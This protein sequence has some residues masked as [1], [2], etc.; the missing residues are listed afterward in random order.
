M[1][2]SGEKPDDIPRRPDLYYRNTHEWIS[3]GNFLG[4]T[5]T[6]RAETV[7]KTNT[8][9]F[10]I[11]NPKAEKDYFR[12]GI[13]NGGA[14]SLNDYL[15]KINGRTVCAYFVPDTFKPDSFLGDFNIEE[16]YEYKGYYRIPS[17][18]LTQVMAK[19]SIKYHRVGSRTA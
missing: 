17:N 12:C 7:V 13:T 5:I 4:V 10:I 8:I 19:L 6:S 9:F 2:D 1:C 18:E 3:W 11:Y 14:S 15:R 16:H